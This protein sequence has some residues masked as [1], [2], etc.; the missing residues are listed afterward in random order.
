MRGGSDGE[1]F[2]DSVFGSNPD[3]AG[4]FDHLS[5]VPKDFLGFGVPARIE[6]DQVVPE[7]PSVLDY[8]PGGKTLRN[9]GNAVGQDSEWRQNP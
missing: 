3:E 8:L 9:V 1:L 2:I 6:N 7:E 5:L 4:V